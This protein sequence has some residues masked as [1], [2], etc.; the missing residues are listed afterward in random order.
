[1]TYGC[2]QYQDVTEAIDYI[3]E[4]YCVEIDRKIFAM[5]FSMGANWL[6]MALCKNKH[7]FSDKIVAAACIQAPM[8]MRQSYQQLKVVWKGLISWGLGCR[9][10]K[11]FEQNIDYLTPIYK[12]K[13]DVDL[14]LILAN[15]TGVHQMEE[16]VNWKVCGQNSFEEY[17]QNFSCANFLEKI[18]VPTL[19]YSCEDDP[20]IT[21]K[22]IEVQR[23][24]KN[25]YILMASTKYGAHL[26]SYEHFFQID[27]WLPKPAFEFLE[28]FKINE[29]NKPS[30][31][32]QT[33]N[34][35]Y[36]A[37]S[38]EEQLSQPEI[39]KP[40]T[41]KEYETDNEVKQRKPKVAAEILDFDTIATD[42]SNQ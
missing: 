14:K 41:A 28:Y 36:E 12:Q 42:R 18:K 7:S 4:E 21:P 11:I 5:G 2:G 24:L 25:D 38:E 40:I 23:S 15:L 27:Q 10:A 20:I 13:Y 9:Y 30:K 34:I 29:I 26:C 8:K 17:H 31:K 22:S 6:G 1:M 37:T 19:F 33:L 16:K 3:H 32:I 39:E 35:M